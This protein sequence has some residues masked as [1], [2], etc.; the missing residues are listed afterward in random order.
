MSTPAF[1]E[2]GDIHY[3]G[4]EPLGLGLSVCCWKDGKVWIERDS[5]TSHCTL[6]LTRAEALDARAAA[7]MARADARRQRAT[8]TP[9]ATPAAPAKPAARTKA[10]RAKNMRRDE[11]GRQLAKGKW[12]WPPT[13]VES[14][15]RLCERAVR[16]Q[17]YDGWLVGAWRIGGAR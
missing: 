3:I 13:K 11:R 2:F 12:K 10:H 8:R 16:P 6:R 14:Y 4:D 9:S 1:S 7:V 17:T 5:P 15:L